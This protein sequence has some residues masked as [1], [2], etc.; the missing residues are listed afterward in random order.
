MAKT[1]P[2]RRQ[3][4]KSAGKLRIFR[5][6]LLWEATGG[7]IPLPKGAEGYKVPPIPFSERRAMLDSMNRDLLT[8]FK[9]DPK[10]EASAF[11]ILKGEGYGNKR[12]SREDLS[13]GVSSPAADESGNEPA[14]SDDEQLDVGDDAQSV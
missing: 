7:I 3:L 5:D 8:S 12:Q 1:P 4:D 6:L 2:V 13:G 14:V 10:D 11:E 9:V